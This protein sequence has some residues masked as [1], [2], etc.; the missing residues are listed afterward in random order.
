MKKILK[1]I[2]SLALALLSLTSFAETKIQFAMEATYPP[3]ESIDES[4]NIIGF[5][6]DIAKAICEKI[7][8]ECTFVNAP[9]DSLIPSLK[10]G[11]FDAL[12]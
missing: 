10:L 11:K 4:G 12:I 5:D 3:F 1:F 8:A 6:V 2:P 9:F 7:N